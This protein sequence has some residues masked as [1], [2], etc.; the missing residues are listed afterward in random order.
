MKSIKPHFVFS[1]QQRS[2][3]F[4]LM[5]IIIFLQCFYFFFDFTNEFSTVINDE[6]IKSFQSELDSL[7]KVKVSKNLIYP[8]NPNFISDHKGYLLGM[9][10]D[11]VDRL[12]RYRKSGKFVNS[13]DDFQKITDISDSLLQIISLNFKF[14]EWIVKNKSTGVFSSSYERDL[15]S[16]SVNDIYKATKIGYKVVS[17]I[18]NYRKKLNGFLSFDQ[19]YDV[20]GLSK[21]NVENIKQKFVLES[22]PTI[23]KININLASAIELSQIVYI[24]DYL[25]VNIVDERVLREGFT[26]LDQLRFVQGFPLEKLERIKLYLTIN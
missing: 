3:V 1:K 17:R 23:Q 4:V 19:L 24:S 7:A 26:N 2:G 12:H 5:A 21:E 16:A 6:K 20:Y 18:I 25:A 9:S 14:P 22:F 13:I 11:E 15:N 10:L 8:F